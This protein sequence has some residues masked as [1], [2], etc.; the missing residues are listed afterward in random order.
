VNGVYATENHWLLTEV[1]RDEWGFDGVVV[2]DWGAVNDRDAAIAAGL[3]LEMPESQAG[4]AA[5]VAAV[6]AGSLDEASLD[7]A[8]R[9][10]LSLVFDHAHLVAEPGRK[11]AVPEE[12]AVAHHAL[13]REAA[14]KAAVLLKNEGDI[15]PLS[16]DATLGTRVREAR[17]SSRRGWMTRSPRSAASPAP[18]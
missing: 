6:R 4:P 2:S 12:L 9:N 8:V 18:T 17:R 1:L 11:L 16:D 10:V 14:S 13:A 7:A 15:L 3:D 5:I